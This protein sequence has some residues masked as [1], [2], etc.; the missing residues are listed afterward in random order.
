M[1]M[2]FIFFLCLLIPAISFAEIFE[3]HSVAQKE[4]QPSFWIV[5]LTDGRVGFFDQNDDLSIAPMSLAGTIIDADLS[6]DHILTSIHIVGHIKEDAAPSLE[7]M[8]PAVPYSPTIYPTYGYA[9]DILSSLRRQ[10]KADAQCYDKAHIWT[11]EEAYYGRNL[12]KAFLFFSD[13]YISRY[14]YQWWFHTSPFAL[15]MLNG[16]V[17]ERVMDASF[18]KYPLKFKLWTDI[19]MKNKAECKIIEKYS[20]YSG[21]PG[22]D[23]C[24]MMK[25]SMYFWQPKDLDAY[26]K[27]G[28]EKKYFIDWEVKHAYEFGF[29]IK[30]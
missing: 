12:Q 3:V 22:E 11:Y 18:T 28:V 23:D 5:K 4:N 29:G 16:E 27:T 9:T 19:F 13:S 20:D 7:K 30:L 25:V 24:Y 14:N 2:K 10:W 15:V 6:E 8:L 1:F 17:V 21:H 26:E